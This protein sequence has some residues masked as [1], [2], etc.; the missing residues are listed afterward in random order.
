MTSSHLTT[1]NVYHENLLKRLHQRFDVNISKNSRQEVELASVLE[2]SVRQ[3]TINNIDYFVDKQNFVYQLKQGFTVNKS[4]PNQC[5]LGTRIGE[6]V[7]N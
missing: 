1:T 7:K 4:F 5:L 6:L 3:F 2:R